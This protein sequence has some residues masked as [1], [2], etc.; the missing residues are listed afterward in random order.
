MSGQSYGD[1][2][3]VNESDVNGSPVG[4]GIPG[5]HRNALI[6]IFGNVMPVND[7]GGTPQAGMTV[8]RD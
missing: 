8:F 5:D 7:P 6:T 1:N 3:F 2:V 4:E